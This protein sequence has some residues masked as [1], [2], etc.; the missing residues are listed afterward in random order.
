L[1]VGARPEGASLL[2]VIQF[3]ARIFHLVD[4]YQCSRIRGSLL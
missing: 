4:G 2:L 1:A 3:T